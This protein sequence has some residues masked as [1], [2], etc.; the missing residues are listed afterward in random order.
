M[1]DFARQVLTNRK[2]D[3]K[4]NLILEPEI[5][6]KLEENNIFTE[7]MSQTI[8]V[9]I[10]FQMILNFA[11]LFSLQNTENSEEKEI[12]FKLKMSQLLLIIVCFIPYSQLYITNG[13][14]S[15]TNFAFN[16]L[17]NE[18]LKAFKT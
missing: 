14:L 1:D 9:K 11:I 3:I 17:Y 4:R 15:E 13:A 6:D 16:T 10:L 5:L 18:K 2:I 7:E 8:K 12:H